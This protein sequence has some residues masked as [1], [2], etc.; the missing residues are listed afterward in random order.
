MTGK[1]SIKSQGNDWKDEIS[2]PAEILIDGNYAEVKY[3]IDGDECTL[4]VCDGSVEQLRRGEVDIKLTFKQGQKT[5]CIL[6]DEGMRGG[7]E[8]F[9]QLLH[10]SIGA[11]G[12]FVKLHYTSGAD[13]EVIKMHITAIKK[14]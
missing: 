9:T 1:I 11:L 4:K 12:V 14:V 8:I 13:K 6:G 2:S 7:Y 3:A 5:L 10:S